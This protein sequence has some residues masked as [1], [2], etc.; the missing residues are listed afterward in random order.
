[1]REKGPL[2][3]N[4]VEGSKNIVLFYIDNEIE[5]ADSQARSVR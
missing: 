2:F 4:K 3:I 1:M 5:L